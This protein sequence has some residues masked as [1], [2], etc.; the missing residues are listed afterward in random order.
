MK[1]LLLITLASLNAGLTMAS[2]QYHKSQEF[3]PLCADRCFDEL[4]GV[5]FRN[6]THPSGI[7]HR[8]DFL[9]ALKERELR[10]CTDTCVGKAIQSARR[11]PFTIKSW[12]VMK[13]GCDDKCNK[14]TAVDFVEFNDEN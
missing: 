10:Y 8:C 13:R 11:N 12:W 7:Y 14:Q 6:N 5:A 9:C 3:T 4:R 1:L 2:P